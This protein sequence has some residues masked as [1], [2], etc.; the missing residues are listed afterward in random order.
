MIFKK[1]KKDELKEAC[2]L[3]ALLHIFEMMGAEVEVC[4]AAGKP[5][6]RKATSQIRAE[7]TETPDEHDVGGIGAADPMVVRA[8]NTVS[9][10]ALDSRK[11]K[12]AAVYRPLA[13]LAAK[14]GI[15]Q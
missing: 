10:A 12:K 5:V 6:C 14:L 15:A 13:V 2:E 4:D 3:A 9:A 8:F 1:K 11:M 7:N